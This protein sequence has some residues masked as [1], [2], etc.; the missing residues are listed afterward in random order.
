VRALE[1]LAAKD[2][3]A[4]S[5]LCSEALERKERMLDD[6]KDA[7][8]EYMGFNRDVIGW[9][10]S[11]GVYTP[12]RTMWNLG[13]AGRLLDSRFVQGTKDAF[14]QITESSVMRDPRV[15]IGAST[16]GWE[17]SYYVGYHTGQNVYE[18]SRFWATNSLW[19]QQIRLKT[20]FA[21]TVHKWW[22]DRIS[23]FSRYTS[24]YP[25]PVQSDMMYAPHHQDKSWGSYIKTLLVTVPFQPR[26]YTDYFRARWQDAISFTGAG[27][28]AA[29]YQ[30]LGGA[31]PGDEGRSWLRNQL[32]RRGRESPHYF[33]TPF[34]IASQQRYVDQVMAFD[35]FVDKHGRE[36]KVDVDGENMSLNEARDRLKHAAAAM[37]YETENAYKK[38]I[39]DT[40]GKYVRLD[41]RRGRFVRDVF[42]GSDIQEDGSR[43][44]F[45]DMYS[46]FH[47]NVFSPTI[48]GM[49]HSAP[50][51]NSEWH[52]Y[53]QVARN[54]E[55]SG[56]GTVLHPTK[57]YWEAS[58]DKDEG[59]ITFA[60]RFSTREDAVAEAYRN[61][62]PVLMHLMKMQQKDIHYSPINTPSL[63]FAS[64]IVFGLGRKLY[65]TAVTCMPGLESLQSTVEPHHAK[66]WEDM[67]ANIA[68]LGMY[69]MYGDYRKKKKLARPAEEDA[70][71]TRR[72]IYGRASQLA[73]EGD[74]SGEHLSEVN[75]ASRR[76]TRWLENAGM[77]T[78]PGRK[79]IKVKDRYIGAMLKRS[80]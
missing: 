13:L 12:Q 76:L 72:V 61:D 49:L 51:G 44:R 47:S 29:A 45:L 16:P 25:A 21:Y 35:D 15:A 66:E 65:R 48:P 4:Y 34:R 69:G 8:K 3:A 40:I 37:D 31:G 14:Y 77:E 18:R 64:P 73:H 62:V 43:N 60:D 17:H 6:Y 55:N 38:K 24:G 78:M 32:D 28:A 46:V 59:R 30:S 20:D 68:T 41:D 50:L 11:G 52:T 5:G 67:A 2:P 7:K 75:A 10:G 70:Y 23:F 79:K 53:P 57:H 56:P 63:S 71:E 54:V 33:S 39:S 9:T 58:Y 42:S 74:I 27:A 80:G 26:A 36:M 22:N 19:E 1:R